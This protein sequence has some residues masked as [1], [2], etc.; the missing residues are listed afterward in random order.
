METEIRMTDRKRTMIF[1]NIVIT[2]IA[3]SMLA[4]ALTT[5]LPAIISDLEISVTAGQWLTSGYSLAMGIIMPLTAFLITRFPTKRLFL[6]GMLLFIVGLSL[7]VVAPDFQVMMAARIL[8]ACG[9]GILTSMAQVII[10][11]IYPAEKRGTAMG[12]Y[13]LS[14]G[15]APVIAPTLAGIIVDMFGWRAIFY[16]SIGIMMIS[17]VWAVFVFDNILETAR[18]KFD[19]LSFVLSIFA[20]GGLTLGIG[21]IGSYSFMS[22][23][24]LPVLVIGLCASG[25]FVYRQLHLEEPFLELRILKKK[26]YAISVVGSMLLYFVMMGSS[27]LMPLY[28]QSIMGCSATVSGLIV[29]PGSAVMAVISPFAGK[30]YDKLGM[31]ILFV[32]GAVCMAVSCGG[33]CFLTMD[34][35]VWVAAAWNTLRTTAIGCLM[36]PLVTWGTEGIGFKKLSH[37]TA[38]LTSLRTVAGAMGTAVF[39]GIMTV[40]AQNGAEK[41]GDEAALHGLTTAF[42]W[43]TIVTLLLVLM[44]I[45]FVK[46]KE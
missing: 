2:C 36:M 15:A 45:F 17:L 28:A 35:P 14:I 37:G 23:Q 1:I 32:T 38:L 21:N 5:A 12:W 6:T 26:N 8:Q 7:C 39:V 19:T 11:T 22:A 16:I 43:M 4:T 34:T 18:K 13:G 46:K 20:F 10:L 31:K 40:S 33:M 25:L 30:I 29:L 27:M 42:F 44:G 3:S 24:V 41:Y 9:N